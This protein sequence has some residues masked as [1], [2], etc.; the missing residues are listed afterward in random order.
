MFHFRLWLES[1]KTKDFIDKTPLAAKVSQW[2]LM[3]PQVRAFLQE[4]DDS[5]LIKP[6]KAGKVGFLVLPKA[7]QFQAMTGIQRY[8]DSTGSPYQHRIPVKIVSL[9]GTDLNVERTDGK[10]FA[11]IAYKFPHF[12]DPRTK[13]Q[14]TFP[15]SRVKLV[16]NDKYT[17]YL[18]WLSYA[19]TKGSQDATKKIPAF[20]RQFWMLSQTGLEASLQ[21]PGLLPKLK[22]TDLAVDYF[23]KQAHLPDVPKQHRGG[24]GA[25]DGTALIEFP[26]GFRWVNLNREA[27]RAEGDAGGHCGNTAEPRH[28]DTVLSLRDK[29]NRV[30]LTF[31]INDGEM[32]EMKANGNRKPDKSMH[33]YIIALLEQPVVKSIGEARYMPE[34][35]F[36]ITDLDYTNLVKLGEKRP[37]L[38]KIDRQEMVLIKNRDNMPRMVSKLEKKHPNIKPLSVVG[39]DFETHSFALAAQ[40]T[41]VPYSGDQWEKDVARLMTPDSSRSHY[42]RNQAI[43][44]LYDNKGDIPTETMAE[45]CNYYLEAEKTITDAQWTKQAYNADKY[46]DTDR[47]S[48]RKQVKNPKTLSQETFHLILYMLSEFDKNFGALLDQT[49]YEAYQ[50]TIMRYV[51]RKLRWEANEFGV[52]WQVAMNKHNITAQQHIGRDDLYHLMN[53]PDITPHA[54]V[55]DFNV[56]VDDPGVRTD[57]FMTSFEKN[58]RFLHYRLH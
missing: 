32:G 19:I 14:A 50:A 55:E 25:A 17:T 18:R 5:A 27:C 6:L 43:A 15:A 30:Y 40:T 35:N 13:L 21:Q 16:D 34:N 38:V 11:E 4:V 36:K 54:E 20:F 3:Q 42:Y 53:N 9:D 46:M 37:D 12:P 58:K 29:D 23:I 7:E 49:W 24:Q 57:M 41:L 22:T 26:N 56:S 2:L 33:P 48:I 39:Y 31:I 47:D 28:G 44:V 10:N 45:L 51:N 8:E 1:L 52:H